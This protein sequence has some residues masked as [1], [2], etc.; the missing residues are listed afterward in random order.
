MS[1]FLISQHSFFFKD[2]FPQL[3]HSHY[4]S[5]QQEPPLPH[6]QKKKKKIENPFSHLALAKE[7]EAGTR[8]CFKVT[9]PIPQSITECSGVFLSFPRHKAMQG[10]KVYESSVFTSIVLTG[11][12]PWWA[13]QE[14]R[15]CGTKRKM[16]AHLGTQCTSLVMV[17]NKYG[18]S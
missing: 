18:V 1:L 10:S 9:S 17:W 6:W 8:T 2:F 5:Q 12:S 7:T 11:L 13:W 16:W 15:E 3:P 14:E 4:Q